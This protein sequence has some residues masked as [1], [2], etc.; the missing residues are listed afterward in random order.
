MLLGSIWESV[1]PHC[2]NFIVGLF[3]MKMNAK[4]ITKKDNS[5]C[6]LQLQYFVKI[7]KG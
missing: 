4:F 3:F 7:V 1:S 5:R 6:N 2:M